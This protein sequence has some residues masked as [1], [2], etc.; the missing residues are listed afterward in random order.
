MSKPGIRGFE[1][2]KTRV[3]ENLSWFANPIK[4]GLFNYKC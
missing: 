3:F 2:T 4:N 1:A